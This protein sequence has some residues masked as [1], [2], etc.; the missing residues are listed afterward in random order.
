MIFWGSNVENFSFEGAV[1]KMSFLENNFKNE[2]E[3]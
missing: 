1:L 2:K 3:N